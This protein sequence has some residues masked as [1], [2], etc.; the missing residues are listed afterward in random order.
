MKDHL[1]ALLTRVM[2]A[3][4]VVV[5]LGACDQFKFKG[6]VTT[7]KTENGHTT[8]HRREVD[9][10]EDMPGAISEAADEMAEVTQ[11]LIKKLTD[12]PPPGNVK[13]GDLGAGFKDFEGKKEF[14]F[15]IQAKEGD[16][17]V[18]FEYVQIGVPDYDKF[19]KTTMEIYALT[20]QTRQSL[21]RARLLASAILDEDIDAKASVSAAVGRAL[22]SANVDSKGDLVPKLKAFKDI[23]Q[24]LA[25]VVPAIVDKVSTLVSLGQK[26]ILGAPSAITNPKVV[27]H[28]GLI[29]KG[30]EDSVK[31][32]K[33]AGGNLGGIVSDVSGFGKKDA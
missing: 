11:K 29:K 9:K 1:F 28:L 15:L 21:N 32:I 26:L 20:Y 22:G 16:K 17:P 13:L 3:S 24:M 10:L 6:Q 7:V 2:L 4:F 18:S 30:L 23:G 8:V 31:V 27:L 12:V 5:G 25:A 14:D 33:E 19:F